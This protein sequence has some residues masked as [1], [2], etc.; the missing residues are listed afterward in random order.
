MIKDRK[1]KDKNKIWSTVSSHLMLSVGSATLSETK[2][3][4]TSLP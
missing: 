4:E 1:K 2:Y 3:K